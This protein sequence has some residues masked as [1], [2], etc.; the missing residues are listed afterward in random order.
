MIGAL[1]VGLI[2]AQPVVAAEEKREQ[3]Q[4]T[5]DPSGAR[6][7]M[8]SGQSCFTP[9]FL[10]L[11]T[12]RESLL[13]ISKRSEINQAKAKKTTGVINRPTRHGTEFEFYQSKGVVWSSNAFIE[14]FKFPQGKANVDDVAVK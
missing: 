1:L 4:V 14:N 9:C 3:V 6:I 10:N 8:R 7:S 12:K 11:S 2:V 13:I 5:S